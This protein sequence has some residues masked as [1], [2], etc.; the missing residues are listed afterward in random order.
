M[1]NTKLQDATDLAMQML[2][3]TASRLE[4][5]QETVQHSG[6][7]DTGLIEVTLRATSLECHK[8]HDQ[9]LKVLS[10]WESNPSEG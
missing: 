8:L 4:E 6:L 2:R 9:I 7:D 3:V 5:A 1:T 10:E